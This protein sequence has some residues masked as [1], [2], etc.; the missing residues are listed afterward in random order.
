MTRALIVREAGP[1]V[2]VQ[3]LGRPGQLAQGL[4]RGGAA[5]RLALAEGAALLAQPGSLAAV[6]MAGFGGAF[7]AEEDLVIALTGAPMQAQIDGAPVVW[8]ASHHLARGAVLRIG[9]ARSGVY[10]YLHVA[11]GIDAPLVLG[12]RSAHLTAGIG[13][14]LARGD[15]LAVGAGGK[16]RAGLRL[17]P[18][19][20]FDGGEVRIIDSLQTAHF[21]A[22]TL[23]R[24]QSATFT[25]DARAN[26]MGVRLAA[27][28]DGFP[29]PGG[30]QVLSEVI[31]PGDIQVT[32]DG[33]PFVL[34]AECQTTGGYPRIATVIP[35]DL[36]KIVQA[37]PGA[38]ITFRRVGHDEALAAEARYRAEIAALP[39][40]IE[41]L[42]RDPADIENLLTYQLISG[43]T[44]GEG[45]DRQ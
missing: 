41:P 26:R 34:I 42:V 10:G 25:R 13:R 21:P 20:R 19:P 40:R 31:V 23:A 32:G 12:A 38:R 2:T 17:T 29:A 24:F 30:L 33:M 16:G 45:E 6:E 28:G 36:P 7:E 11:G 39:R 22:E 4:S 1:G 15:R 35:A 9:G 43:V 5:D 37:A 18:A 3:D 44:S 8:N 27:A 14:A